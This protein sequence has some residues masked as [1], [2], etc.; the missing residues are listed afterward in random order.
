M[1]ALNGVAEPKVNA[2]GFC[3]LLVVVLDTNKFGVDALL[4]GDHTFSFCT[5]LLNKPVAPPVKE[6]LGCMLLPTD[7]AL[8]DN[9]FVPP[10]VPVP[11][12][13]KVFP[14]SVF[15][16]KAFPLEGKLLLVPNVVPAGRLKAFVL[17]LLSGA[18]K[19]DLNIAGGSV[20]G[21][22][23]LPNVNWN[24]GFSVAAG[25]AADGAGLLG[26]LLPKVNIGPVVVLLVFSVF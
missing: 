25:I 6:L 19:G 11:P 18:A 4:L 13:V 9:P 21:A 24:F 10:R 17:T 22:E 5:V 15:P 16:A 12:I 1:A 3:K 2:A 8:A 7:S 14:P 23:L 26:P 20:L